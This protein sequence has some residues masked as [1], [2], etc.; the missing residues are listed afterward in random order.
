MDI[1]LNR[2]WGV[3]QRLSAEGD[4]YK[5]LLGACII[6]SVEFKTITHFR[7]IETPDGSN[8]LHLRWHDGDDS[9]PL[10]FPLSGPEEIASFARKWLEKQAIYPNKAPDT[11]GDVRRGFRIESGSFYDVLTMK[12]TYIVYGK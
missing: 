5:F 12:P 11:D 10:P 8:E 3:V 1:D 2:D 9:K 7:V 6:A 4:T